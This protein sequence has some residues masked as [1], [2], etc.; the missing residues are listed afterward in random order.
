[1]EAVFDAEPKRW[2]TMF[3]LEVRKIGPGLIEVHA[4][5][6]TAQVARLCTKVINRGPILAIDVIRES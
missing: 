5:L 6:G 3:D 4:I 2:E 1:M